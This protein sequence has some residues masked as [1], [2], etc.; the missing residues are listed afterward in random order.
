[1]RVHENPIMLEPGQSITAA[2]KVIVKDDQ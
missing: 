1:M 2:Y